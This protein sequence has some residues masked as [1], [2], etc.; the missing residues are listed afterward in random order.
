MT[1]VRRA[2]WTDLDPTTAHD[3]LRLRVDVFV[4][5]QAC[6]YPEIDGRDV[7]PATEHVWVGGAGLAVAA[8]LR[9]LFEPDGVRRV[10]RVVA[11]PAARGQG[12]A[13]LLMDDVLAR[14]GEAPLVL[15][16]QSPVAPWY[17]AFGFEPTGPEFLEDGIP[18]VPMRRQV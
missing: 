18:H 1:T 17:A 10:G 2:R 3:I 8:Y 4:V 15:D 13:R 12:F 16:A 5:E 14:H 6:P 7:E 9:V 11:A